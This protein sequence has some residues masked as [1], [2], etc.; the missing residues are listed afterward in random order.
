MPLAMAMEKRND[1]TARARIW[2]TV[3]LLGCSYKPRA[4]FTVRIPT[5][6]KAPRMTPAMIAERLNMPAPAC[7]VNETINVPT[8]RTE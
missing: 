2:P 4:K 7:I 3:N 8:I 1:N 5:A 6:I